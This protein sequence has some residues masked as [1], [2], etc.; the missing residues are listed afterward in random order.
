MEIH[1]E[2][3]AATG[4]TITAQF[5]GGGLAVTT[6]KYG[7]AT[8]ASIAAGRSAIDRLTRLLNLRLSPPTA[9]SWGLS[10]TQD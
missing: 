2:P 1:E 9:R 6:G 4:T 10:G 7:V 5:D 3:G 8:H